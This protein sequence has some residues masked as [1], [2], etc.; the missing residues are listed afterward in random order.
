[1]LMKMELKPEINIE[2]FRAYC[3]RKL[4]KIQENPGS[5]SELESTRLKKRIQSLLNILEEIER[6][7]QA[8]AN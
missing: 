8:V 1:M 4:E 3:F 5:F 7:D 2:S 6:D